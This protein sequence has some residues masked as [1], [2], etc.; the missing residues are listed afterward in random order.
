VVKH[1]SKEH[2]SEDQWADFARSLAA[3]K[4]QMSMQQHIQGGCQKCEE[5]LQVWQSVL[6][7]A[8]KE[9]GYNPPADIVRVVKTQLAA[10][11]AKASRGFRVLFDSALQPLTSGIRGSVSA[12]QFLFETD[13]FYIDLRLEPR[14]EAD[15]A[16]LV[17][18]ILTRKGMDRAAAGVVVHIKKGQ[19]SLAETMANRFGEFQLEFDGAADL[20]ISIGGSEGNEILLP[21]YGMH[22]KSLETRSLD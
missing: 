10:V 11:V 6:D 2:F 16:C 15:R 14:R 20:H 17:G 7:V 21:L 13:D 4:E 1:F 8:V 5:T 22:V 12:R 18:Q 19:H 3:P 9:S